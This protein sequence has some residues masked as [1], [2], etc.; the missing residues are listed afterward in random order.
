M[1]KMTAILFILAMI[2]AVF[3]LTIAS[4]EKISYVDAN[5][6]PM[7]A[8]CAGGIIRKARKRG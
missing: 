5:G 2:L 7:G 8:L 1:K 3:P 6:N 4:A